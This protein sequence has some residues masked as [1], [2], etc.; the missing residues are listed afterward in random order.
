MTKTCSSA[1][2]A[3]IVDGVEVSC[4]QTDNC[5]ADIKPVTSCYVRVVLKRN[6]L[7][8]KHLNYPLTKS[9]VHNYNGVIVAEFTDSCKAPDNVYCE[10]YL[11]E[12]LIIK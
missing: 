1:C 5:N 12:Y 2:S 11:C 3:G 7:F 8:S 6:F 4:C 9:L 10:V